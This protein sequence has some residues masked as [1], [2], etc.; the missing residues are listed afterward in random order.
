MARRR[1]F[2]IVGFRTDADILNPWNTTRPETVAVSLDNEG[3][4][5]I[6]TTS[7]DSVY[8]VLGSDDRSFTQLA[9]GDGLDVQGGLS[10]VVGLEIPMRDDIRAAHHLLAHDAERNRLAATRLPARRRSLYT[11]GPHVAHVLLT[12]R[13]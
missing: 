3:R 1:A 11:P 4:T 7:E 9:A 5:L 2:P 13:L 12:I 8:L 10:L 6:Q